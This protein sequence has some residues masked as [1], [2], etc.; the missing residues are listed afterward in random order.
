LQNRKEY[1]HFK[2]M[3]TDDKSWAIFDSRQGIL[4][5]MRHVSFGYQ[6]HAH[7]HFRLIDGY[8]AICSWTRLIANKAPKT[9]EELDYEV[10][11][12]IIDS[13]FVMK[14]ADATYHKQQYIKSKR[15]NTKCYRF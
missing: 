13:L 12:H 5:T 7:S 8:I 15:R 1:K 4:R 14:K 2:K 10:L 11:H 9:A 6:G 3:A